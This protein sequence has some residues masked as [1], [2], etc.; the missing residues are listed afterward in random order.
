VV[1]PR[2]SGRLPYAVHMH[3][4]LTSRFVESVTR[5]VRYGLE[6]PPPLKRWSARL[7]HRAQAPDQRLRVRASVRRCRFSGPFIGTYSAMPYAGALL[8]VARGCWFVKGSPGPSTESVESNRLWISSTDESSE[9]QQFTL[10]F[11]VDDC[12]RVITTWLG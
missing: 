3:A 2:S 1:A 7:V 8:K 9:E 4:S 12:C 5:G 10:H 6:P 11:P